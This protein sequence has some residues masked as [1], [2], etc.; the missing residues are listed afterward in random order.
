MDVFSRRIIGFSVS[1]AYINGMD[2]CRMFNEATTKQSLP[3]YL[4]SDNDPLFRYHR[5][6]ATLGVL[7]IEEIKSVPYTPVSHPFVERMIRTVRQ[8]YLNHALFF[9]QSDLE[10]KLGK[11]KDYYNQHRV[12]K[13]LISQTPFEKADNL[14]PKTA[15]LDN[16]TW[17]S[18]C[19]GLFQTPIAV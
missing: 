18:H 13:S 3:T 5:W 19:N 2:V 7:D 6:L 12:H 9:G 15:N 11:F 4:S 8:E 10:R 14:K 1:P 17:L 16:F